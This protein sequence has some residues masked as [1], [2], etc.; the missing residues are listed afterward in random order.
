MGGFGE[1]GV[2]EVTAHLAKSNTSILDDIPAAPVTSLRENMLFKAEM[3]SSWMKVVLWVRCEDGWQAARWSLNGWVCSMK[4]VVIVIFFERVPA[5]MM[6][7][8]PCRPLRRVSYACLVR[9]VFLLIFLFLLFVCTHFR[10][11]VSQ[12]SHTA[13]RTARGHVDS[14]SVE[15]FGTD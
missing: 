9:L 1:D 11:G 14:R 2:R 3:E 12:V 7:G 10:L 5:T 4:T 6:R 8:F 15:N 13:Q